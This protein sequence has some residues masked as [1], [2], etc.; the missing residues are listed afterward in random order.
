M[1]ELFEPPSQHKPPTLLNAVCESLFSIHPPPNVDCPS[2]IAALIMVVGLAKSLL[3][4][5]GENV[6]WMRESKHLADVAS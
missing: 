1:R 4:N 3:A 6:L 5:G 2:Y